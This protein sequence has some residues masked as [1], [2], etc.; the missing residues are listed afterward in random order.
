[1]CLR[2][3]VA[4][5]PEAKRLGYIL[6]LPLVDGV[7][8]MLVLA[9]ML[10]SIAGILLVGVVVF[11]GTGAI[12]VI[13]ADLVEKPR[14]HVLAILGIGAVIVPIAGIQAAIAPTLAS[15]LDTVLLTY[16]AAIV[17]VIL[18]A[19]IA[20]PWLRR[21]SPRLW[22]VIALGLLI[23]F[24]PNGLQIDASL[25]PALA[26]AGGASAGVGIVLALGALIVGSRIRP[27]ID[28]DR[29]RY[30]GG[31]ALSLV[32]VSLVSPIPAETAV[33]VMGLGLLFAIRSDQSRG[34]YAHP[35][36]GESATVEDSLPVSRPAR[37][38]E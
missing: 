35:H 26:L 13:L 38:S 5:R 29:F 24:R 19:E 25:D 9:G 22:I 2:G 3:A 4:L 31:I 33:L 37:M 21:R 34:G 16:V 7:F 27:V 8:V 23:S 11:A 14:K 20:S 10:D 18:G 1:M 28:R 15:V 36:K 17:L 30:A 32:A 6:G 12:A